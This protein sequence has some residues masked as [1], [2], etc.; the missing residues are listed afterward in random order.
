MSV[1]VFI[2]GV[3]SLAADQFFELFEDSAIASEIALSLWDGEADAGRSLMING[4]STLV[5]EYDQAPYA[6]ANVVVLA[7]PDIP[8]EILEMA[9][10]GATLIDLYNNL[11]ADSAELAIAGACSL[12]S[13][14]WYRS[15][16]PA[17]LAVYRFCDAIKAKVEPLRLNLAVA[18]PASAHDRAGVE[19][20]ALETAALLNGREATEQYLG[21]TLA[22][23]SLAQTFD[24]ND[25]SETAVETRIAND[26]ELLFEDAETSV[27]TVQVPMF[28]GTSVMLT[29]ESSSKIEL[30]DVTAAVD[31]DK[32]LRWSEGKS[33]ATQMM[34][35]REECLVT[36]VRKDPRVDQTLLATL[37]FDE[38][39]FGR[40][41]N[42]MGLLSSLI[43]KH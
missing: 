4:H 14:Q 8:K 28:H 10:E 11:E 35:G 24:L 43:P 12:E 22:F 25:Q 20:L 9:S 32:S 18:L 33:T 13:G 34:I 7:A 5:R 19:A 30:A 42:L 41:A 15:P 40:A 2:V 37:M 38:Q 31:R 17:L 1:K 39:R 3:G 16:E 26:A 27:S 6:E 21:A 23:N 36:R 29:I